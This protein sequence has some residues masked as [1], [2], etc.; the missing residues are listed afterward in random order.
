M[1]IM[2]KKLIATVTITRYRERSLKFHGKFMITVTVLRNI[3]GNG[4]D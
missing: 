1:I 4:N 3:H 2:K